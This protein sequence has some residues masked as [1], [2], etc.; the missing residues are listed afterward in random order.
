[1][2]TPTLAKALRFATNLSGYL[3]YRVTAMANGF[4]NFADAL[5]GISGW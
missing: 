1:M 5:Y 4:R 3:M 2:P